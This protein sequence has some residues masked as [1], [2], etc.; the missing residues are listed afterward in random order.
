MC[1]A[2]RKSDFDFAFASRNPD[3]LSAGRAFVNVI[4]SSLAETVADSGKFLPDACGVFQIELIL[5]VSFGMI[6]RKHSKIGI[7]QDGEGNQ[8]QKAAIPGKSG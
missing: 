7:N 4:V 1:I 2:F 6:P 8:V 3:L 5:C